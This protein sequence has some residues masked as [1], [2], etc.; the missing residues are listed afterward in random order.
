MSDNIVGQTYERPWGN[1]KTLD[2]GEGFQVKII[3]VRPDGRLSLQKHF[4]RAEHWIVV[5][6]EPKITVNKKAKIFK[7]GD[8]VYIPVETPHRLEN[9]T[10]YSVA[11]IEVQIGSYLGEDDIERLEDVYGRVK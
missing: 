3:K 1:Y 8:H 2:L 10:K 7:V 11:I 4:K 9:L 6:G 5:E